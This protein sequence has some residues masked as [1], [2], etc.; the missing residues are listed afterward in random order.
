MRF[1]WVSMADLAGSNMILD[2]SLQ[3]PFWVGSPLS[4]NGQCPTYKPWR[5]SKAKTLRHKTWPCWWYRSGPKTLIV[6]KTLWSRNRSSFSVKIIVRL[7]NCN[8]PHTQHKW[9]LRVCI[10]WL[11]SQSEPET[12][13]QFCVIS[14]LKRM[15][16][17][18]VLSC[19]CT[20]STR[21]QHK[22]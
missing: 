9:E 19:F 21:D 20:V 22:R 1:R 7:L 14:V 5:A 10:S 8:F 4:L 11:C 16:L 3:S 13:Q 17:P 18:Y 6:M 2:A 12:S 15:K